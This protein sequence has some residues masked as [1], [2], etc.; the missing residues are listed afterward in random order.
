MR[1]RN[2]VFF[3]LSILALIT[4]GLA[5]WYIIDFVLFWF[6]PRPPGFFWD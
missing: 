1:K 5:G 6:C 4:L 2:Q 3:F